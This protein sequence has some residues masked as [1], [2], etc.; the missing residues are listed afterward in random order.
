MYR[1]LSLD[2]GGSWALLQLLTLK[3]HY[4]NISG[5][6]VLKHF[7]LVVANSG[8]SI[9]LAALCENWNLEKALGLFDQKEK[10]ELIFSK[11]SFK[12]RFFPIDYIRLFGGKFGPKYS[13][14]RKKEAFDSLFKQCSKRQ[15]H[16][17]HDF[18][19]KGCPKLVVC[20]YD[21]LNN[22]AKFFRS[23]SNKNVFD[24][25]TLTQAIHG[26]S[27]A[28]IQYFDF[29]ARFK[30]SNTEVFYE[31]WDGALGGFNNPIVVGIIEALKMGISKKD[32]YI[33]SIGTGNKIMS[34]EE[35]SDFWNTKLE[36]QKN[37][38]K[39]WKLNKLEVQFKFF[40]KSI[41][42]QAKTILYQP[43]DWANYVA[44]MFLF[45]EQDVFDPKRII[46]LSPMIHTDKNDVDPSE[47]YKKL[48]RR[49]YAMDMDLTN[50]SDIETL[51][52][53]FDYWSSDKMKNQPIEFRVT[54]ENELVYIRGSKHFSEA[55]GF[56][57]NLDN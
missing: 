30:A 40:S 15:M 46:R 20:T 25:I 16:E 28:P 14:K 47:S 42:Q 54:R 27:N 43:P 48:I 55:I 17:L 18:I 22:R 13:S 5:H 41:L 23:F 7:D 44:Y 57:K 56:W 26:S 1:I 2:G 19:G 45:G 4:G 37:R 49:L 31:L 29:P 34:K 50:D 12:E 38:S 39:K 52:M 9:V 35:K 6:E 53:C 24:S 11:N 8:G 10:R 21:A 51:K 32:I 3:Y 36:T 33:V